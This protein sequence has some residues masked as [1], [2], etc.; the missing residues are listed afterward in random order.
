MWSD[1]ISISILEH[2]VVNDSIP[3]RK[4]LAPFGAY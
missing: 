4:K 2:W 3:K 1:I